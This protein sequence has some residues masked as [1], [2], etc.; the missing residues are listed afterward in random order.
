MSNLASIVSFIGGECKSE[1]PEQLAWR[2][3]PVSSAEI[4]VKIRSHVEALFDWVDSKDDVRQIGE[5]EQGLK[6]LLFALGRL[7]F[8][9]F[10]TVREERSSKVVDTWV[11]R[12][13]RR[14]KLERKFV[15]T[16]FGCVC[17]WRTYVRQPGGRGNHPLDQALGLTADGFSLEVIQTAA[18]LSTLTSYEQVTALLLHFWGWSPS[19]TTVEKAVLGLGRY[20]QEWFA[21]APPPEG[22]GEVL[23]MQ[24]DSKATPTATEEELQKR[25]QRRGEKKPALSPRHRGRE[26][27]F[28][29]KKEKRRK[30]GDKSK[31]GKATTIVV[32]YTLKKGRDENGERVLL[33]PINKWVYASYAPKR[34][35]FEIARREADKRG[36]TKGSRKTI[37]VVTDGDEDLER[38]TKELFPKAKH[39]LDIMHALE[40]LWEAGRFLFKEGSDELASWVKKQERLLY[41]GKSVLVMQHVGDII[42]QVGPAAAKRLEE[43]QTYLFK[44]LRLINYDELRKQ[45]LEV[46]SGAVEGAVRHVIAKRFDFGSMR[47]IRERAEALLQLRC[48]EINGDWAAFIAFVAERLRR[49]S[50]TNCSAAR[51]LTTKQNALPTLE[52]AA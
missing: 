30:S 22:D 45:D 18:R 44:R 27:R 2:D 4:K 5:V 37:Q 9:Y 35:I 16:I 20:T 49:E 46:A 19:K 42:K 26:K 39:T 8:A 12:G 24:F 38:Y 52:K 3:A 13:W 17:F 31:N 1:T 43:I 21:Q 51:L 28:R 47:W 32:M 48:I 34:H 6:P 15:N 36:F 11:Q 10:L 23:V 50:S 41:R 7:L 33:G 25:R 40:Y 29:R 14:R